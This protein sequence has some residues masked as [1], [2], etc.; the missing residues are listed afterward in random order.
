MKRKKLWSGVQ[1]P[2]F[3]SVDTSLSVTWE[4]R[5]KTLLGVKWRAVTV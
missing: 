2:K 4:G 1:A 3:S 5:D